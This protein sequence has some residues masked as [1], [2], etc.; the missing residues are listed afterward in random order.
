MAEKSIFSKIID[1]DIPSNII[2]ETD[3]IIV[4]EDINPK[5]SIHYL[6]ISK[7]VIPD[8]Q[9]MTGNDF[10]LGAKMFKMAKHLSKTV[11][12]AGDFRFL[13][14]SGEQAGQEIPHLHAHFLAGS[15]LPSF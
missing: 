7:K 10:V 13:I 14:N 6:I 8:I 2:E 11:E 9:S 5:A 12:C 4:I 3:D 15:K 1:R